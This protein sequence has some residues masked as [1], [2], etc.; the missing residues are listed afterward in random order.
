MTAAK[1]GLVA[2]PKSRADGPAFIVYRALNAQKS[3]I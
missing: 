2:A 1:G 3:K